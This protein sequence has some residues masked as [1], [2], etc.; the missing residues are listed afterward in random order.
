MVAEAST[1]EAFFEGSPAGLEIFKTVVGVAK[2][3]GQINVRVTKSQIA[4]RRRRGFAYVWRP[5][6]Y[7]KSEVP[8][9][10]SIALPRHLSSSRF[11]EVVHPSA[12]VWMHHLELRKG[13]DVDDEVRSWMQE[14]YEAAD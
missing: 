10:L 3:L 8:A 11:K 4:L 7:I 13:G 9:V 12:A 14:A 2:D 1:P 5:G 6:Q